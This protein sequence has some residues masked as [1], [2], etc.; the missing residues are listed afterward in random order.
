[1]PDWDVGWLSPVS[2]VLEAAW[3]CW[4]LVFVVSYWRTPPDRRTLA[5]ARGTNLN[6]SLQW[7]GLIGFGL[8]LMFVSYQFVSAA[9][10]G[11]WFPGDYRNSD[12]WVLFNQIVVVIIG[13]MIVVA[14]VIRALKRHSDPGP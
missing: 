4:C 3:L 7:K 14:G 2:S 11:V 5:T 12:W 10:T 9:N 13:P 8:S 6:P 1:M